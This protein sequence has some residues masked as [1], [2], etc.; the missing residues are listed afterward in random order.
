MQYCIIQYSTI[1]IQYIA[2]AITTN[3]ISLV[4]NYYHDAGA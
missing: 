2:I 3:I 1:I 4:H